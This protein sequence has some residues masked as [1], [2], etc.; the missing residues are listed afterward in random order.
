M[1]ITFDI[2]AFDIIQQP[3][4]PANQNQKTSAG[5]MILFMCFEMFGKILNPMG[6]QPDLDLGLA[7][8]RFM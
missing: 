4:A 1:A 5:M 8:I 6:Q 7:G 3:S 2:F